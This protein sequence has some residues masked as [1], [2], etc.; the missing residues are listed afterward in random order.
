ME[1]HYYR[2]RKRVDSWEKDGGTE[3]DRQAESIS[4]EH[5]M[6]YLRGNYRESKAERKGEERRERERQGHRERKR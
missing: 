2:D 3:K 6:T 4:L 5:I 1:V